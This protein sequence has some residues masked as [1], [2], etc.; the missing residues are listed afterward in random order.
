MN[1]KFKLGDKVKIINEETSHYGYKGTI[2]GLLIKNEEYYSAD[3]CVAID[4]KYDKQYGKP[5][6]LKRRLN[7]EDLVEVKTVHLYAYI[8]EYNEVHFSSED[9]SSDDKYKREWKRYSCADFTRELP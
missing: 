4:D 3:Y 7:E 5:K 1:H 9:L 6:L 2:I 8:D